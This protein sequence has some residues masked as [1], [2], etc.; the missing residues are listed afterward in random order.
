MC[1]TVVKASYSCVHQPCISA[2]FTAGGYGRVGPIS[3]IA[4]YDC[5]QKSQPDMP[6]QVAGSKNARSK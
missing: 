6:M 4:F 3:Q 2:S 1:D 5:C